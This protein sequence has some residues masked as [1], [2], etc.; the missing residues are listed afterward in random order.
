LPAA[1]AGTGFDFF[2]P[3]D[4]GVL[5]VGLAVFAAVGALAHQLFSAGLKLERPL[6]FREWTTVTRLIVFAMPLTIGAVALLGA[7]LLGL[8]AGAA[9]LAG[10]FV[11]EQGGSGWAP[12]FLAA[13]V[14]Y[15]IPVGTALGA[16]IG[17]L[18][19]WSV[20]R[21]RSRD[22]L[23]ATFDGFHAI[24]TALV[25]YGLAELAGA[26]GSSACS[27]AASPSAATSATT[28]ST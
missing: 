14:L 7:G 27:R 21:M 5:F 20:K 28:R 16:A 24:A 15:A 18:A 11:V 13:D 1:A 6:A 17:T 26:Y 19:A 3:F 4:L 25:I 8:S 22:L 10:L 23:A 9:L 12:E 2:E